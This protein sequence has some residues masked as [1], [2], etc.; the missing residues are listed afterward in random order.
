MGA[1]NRTAN[2]KHL[3]PPITKKVTE[4]IQSQPQREGKTEN[5]LL[6][7]ALF[8]L[9]GFLRSDISSLPCASASYPTPA[10]RD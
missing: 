10:S 1:S 3:T 8:T 6:A 4:D 9:A 2:S 7:L 5:R